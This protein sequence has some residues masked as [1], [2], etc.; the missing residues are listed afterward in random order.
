MSS[1]RRSARIEARQA[2][3]LPPTR[4]EVRVYGAL[5]YPLFEQT[6]AAPSY[7]LERVNGAVQTMEAGMTSTRIP[8]Y[9]PRL[10][11]QLVDTME[12]NLWSQIQ[13]KDEVLV[14]Q[15]ADL[16]MRFYRFLAAV[17]RDPCYR[18]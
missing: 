14:G 17:H 18:E 6:A 13:G 1:V 8:A 10:R 11:N 7:S 15:I 12:I 4:D 16:R 3:L 5:L 2:R 9:F